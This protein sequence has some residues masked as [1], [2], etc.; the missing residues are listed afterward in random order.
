MSLYKYRDKMSLMR[1]ILMSVKQLKRHQVI[2]HY[3]DGHISRQRASEVLG[4]STRQISRIR[5]GYLEQGPVSLVHKNT[6]RKP[7]HAIKPEVRD[8][9]VVLKRSTTFINTNIKHFQELLLEYHS[10]KISYSALYNILKAAGLSSPLKQRRKK[11]HRRRQRKK[12]M[13]ELLQ[14][15]AT[16]FEWFAGD[17]KK[18]ALHASIDDATGTITGAYL[19]ENENLIGY[20]EIMRQT[21][22]N[23]GVPL[24][25]YSDKHTIFRS[26]ITDKLTLAE[27]I[28]GK[29]VNLTQ[30]G[31][32]LD[33][34]GIRLIY[35]NSPQAKGRIERLWWTL[36]NRLPTELRLRNITTIEEV[37]IFLSEYL[38]I[39][40]EAF[41]INKDA[42]NIFVPYEHNYDIDRFLCVKH[43]RKTDNAGTFSIN[44]ACFQVIDEGYPLIPPKA[45]IEVLISIRKGIRVMYKDRV[46]DTVR[47]IKPDKPKPVK[48]KTVKTKTARI[49]PHLV[50]SSELW[51]KLWHL[52]D[53]DETMN[54]LHDLFLRKN[55]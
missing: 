51:K 7:S 32:S 15:D 47:Y 33:E 13:G 29:K 20:Q 14:I 9:I 31:R 16:P 28:A 50:H 25:I 52:E 30:F 3:I 48:Q 54:F 1:R 26:P 34:L 42:N 38:K 23:Y 53:Y 46:Y 39:F 17:T 45:S 24:C 12:N 22:L 11:K 10:I 2:T 5:K 18:Y 6:G 4:L 40:N 19:T 44:R 21:V 55:A 35:A 37:N 43:T 8:K 41:S 36:Q 49:Q 27:E